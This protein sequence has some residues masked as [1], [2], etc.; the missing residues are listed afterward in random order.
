LPPTKARSCVE[1]ALDHAAREALAR[2]VVKTAITDV[3]GRAHLIE[4]PRPGE[5]FYAA[6]GRYSPWRTCNV[7]A[8]EALADA[9]LPVARWAPFSFGVMWPLQKVQRSD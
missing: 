3:A 7:W 9:G 8:S 6:N 2:F 5:G 1:I 4:S